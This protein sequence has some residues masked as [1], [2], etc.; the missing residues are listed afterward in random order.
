MNDSPHERA[1]TL[2]AQRR[3][4]GV[5]ADEET[6]LAA[7]LSECEACALLDSQTQAALSAFRATHIELPTNLAARTQLR[8]RMRAEQLGER[9][10]G[11][12]LLWAMVGLSWMLGVASAPLVWR[13]FEWVGGELGLP[14]LVLI[15]GMAL[16]WLVPGL[17]VTG[18]V[19]IQKQKAERGAE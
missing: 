10:P 18:A 1:Q 16:W 4:E 12:K 19:V 11:R 3:M 5:S 17:L 13:G 7:H 9:E 14:K 6:F 15:S 2:M 8:V